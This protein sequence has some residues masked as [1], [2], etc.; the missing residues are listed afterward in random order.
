MKFGGSSVADAE[1]IKAIG[2]IVAA[3]IERRPVVVVSALAGVTDLLQRAILAAGRGALEE[4][5]PLLA[6]L[7]R[8]YRWALSGSVESPDVR[9]AL[10]LELDGRFEDLRQR[11]RSIRILREGTRR[12][13]DGLLAE[14]ERLA[15]RIIAASFA[16]HGLPAESVDAA[17][18]MRTDACFG[19]AD[20]D[21]D[22]VRERCASRLRPLVDAGRVPVLGGFFGATADGETT[23]LGRGGSDTSAAVIGAA[24]AVEEIQ[25]WTDVDGLMTADP[26]LVPEAQTLARVSFGEAAELAYY[27]ARVLHPAS[28]APAVERQIPVRV[29]NSMQP[30]GEGTVIL[31]DS[32]LPESAPLASVASR[33][34]VWLVRA[35]SRCLRADGALLPRALDAL[36]RQGV[37]PDLVVSGDLSV[38]AVLPR[39]VE[40]APLADAIGEETEVE[41]L[42]ERAII[43]IVGSGLARE[44][45][46]RDV[47]QAFGE[48]APDLVTIGAS[49]TSVTAVVEAG[50]LASAVRELHR[51]FFEENAYA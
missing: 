49:R 14:G 2:R 35:S 22:A 9:H 16:D 44:T 40:V 20:P 7:E 43:C 33:S 37:V 28:I 38:A 12:A 3:R 42:D 36:K 13:A 29:L 46:R 27:G 30:D 11:L 4:L 8:R 50:R 51:R 17:E 26:R 31:G 34:P 21:L 18:V 25:I 39:P 45:I 19:E 6:D 47:L 32:P 1:R 5:E 23:T 24:M 15:A 10:S 48:W 41:Q